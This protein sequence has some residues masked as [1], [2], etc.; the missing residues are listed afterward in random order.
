M[1]NLKLTPDLMEHLLSSNQS[2]R[3]RAR[4]FYDLVKGAGKKPEPMLEFMEGFF[5]LIEQP[6][7]ED[8]KLKARYEAVINELE[9]GPARPA[10]FIAKA[11]GSLP[12]S[13]QESMSSLPTV[14]KDFPFYIQT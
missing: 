12:K 6:S 10:T 3:V 14:R 13:L 1:S 11:N 8:A 9:T 5:K 4:I 7:P 2:A